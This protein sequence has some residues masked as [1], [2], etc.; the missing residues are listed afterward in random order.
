MQRKI[1]YLINP[2]SGTKNKNTLTT[3][4]ENCTRKEGIRFIIINTDAS[5]K[6]PFLQQLILKEK[7]TDVV[8]CGGDG[9]VNQL[10]AALHGVD[11]NIGIIPMGSGNGLAFTAGIPTNIGDALQIIFKGS[12][13]FIDAFYINDQFSCMLCGLGFD[14]QVAHDFAKQ[15]TRGLLSYAK[16]TIKNFVSAKPFPFTIIANKTEIKTQAYFISIANSNQ[17]GNNVRIAPRA[18]LNDGLLDI[19]VVNKMSKAKMIYKL[20]LQLKLGQV[21]PFTKSAF[22]KEDIHYFQTNKL[23]ILNPGNAPLHIDGEPCTFASTY[24]IVLKANAFKLLQP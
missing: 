4:I 21:I 2:I 6:Y 24:E 18:S 7:I 23:T 20:L 19:V 3:S 8:V 11:V 17:F 12:A 16:Q 22:R 10:A 5:G 9:S 1:I 13:S 14:A 15:T